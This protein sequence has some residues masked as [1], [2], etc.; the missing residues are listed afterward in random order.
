MLFCLLFDVLL[1]FS[2][3]DDSSMFLKYIVKKCRMIRYDQGIP[4]GMHLNMDSHSSMILGSLDDLFSKKNVQ[5]TQSD[6]TK[7]LGERERGVWGG[8]KAIYILTAGP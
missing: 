8:V 6:Y 5:S 7:V 3:N 2:V 1:V 4:A